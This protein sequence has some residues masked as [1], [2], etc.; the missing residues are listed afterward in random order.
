MLTRDCED[1]GS[2]YTDIILLAI[3]ELGE[4]LGAAAAFAKL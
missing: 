4:M 3:V 2:L 1:R